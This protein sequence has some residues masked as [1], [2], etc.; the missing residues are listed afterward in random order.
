M[1]VASQQ[2]NGN[3]QMHQH[4]LALSLCGLLVGHA[5]AQDASPV[6]SQC[7]EW[8]ASVW[9]DA[10]ALDKLQKKTEHDKA[11]K[12][13]SYT[14]GQ[15]V[16]LLGKDPK[17]AKDIL[18]SGRDKLTKTSDG[19]VDLQG[20]EL[21]GFTLSGINL[22]YVDLKG[23][24]LNGTDLSG[25]SLRGASLYKAELVGANLSKA[26]LTSANLAKAKLVDAD[27]CQ[28]S[29]VRADIEDAALKNAYLKGA[30][31]DMVRNLPK[32]FYQH[33]TSIIQFGLP[34][35]PEN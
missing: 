8:K 23:A 9:V 20:A 27:L 13:A 29:L 32:S 17:T 21:N 31:L 22:D 25:A 16:V 33:S 26:D 5:C 28:A 14:K 24:E 3:I 11:E 12:G 19:L 34:V 18:I 7:G 4:V 10:K 1:R 30:R 35:P 6:S 2:S 15:F